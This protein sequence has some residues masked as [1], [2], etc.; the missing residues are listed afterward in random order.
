MGEVVHTVGIGKWRGGTLAELEAD[1]RLVREKHHAPDY[2]VIA[3]TAPGSIYALEVIW[4][5]P[6]RP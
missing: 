4:I 2:A 1:L 6:S 3:T 5:G